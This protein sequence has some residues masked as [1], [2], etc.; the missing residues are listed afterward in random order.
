MQIAKRNAVESKRAAA[1]QEKDRLSVVL[2]HAKI[3]TY[4]SRLQSAYRG[5]QARKDVW[6]IKNGGRALEIS[7]MLA[8]LGSFNSFIDTNRV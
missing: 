8:G 1:S 2:A 4:V 5:F 3:T 6:A 7:D